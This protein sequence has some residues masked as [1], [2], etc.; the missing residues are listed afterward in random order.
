[1]LTPEQKLILESLSDSSSL[2]VVFESVANICRA[3]S[4]AFKDVQERQ[5]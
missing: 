5:H 1:M 3:I 2:A 4:K